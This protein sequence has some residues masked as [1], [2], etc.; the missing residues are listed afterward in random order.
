MRIR[1]F[2]N[3]TQLPKWLAKYNQTYFRMFTLTSAA[4]LIVASG[5]DDV[6]YE[7]TPGVDKTFGGSGKDT[8][9]GSLGADELH[10]EG[11]TDVIDYSKSPEVQPPDD[12]P[13]TSGGTDTDEPTDEPSDEPS[14][15]PTDG[16]TDGPVANVSGGG[17]Q[18]EVDFISGITVNLTTNINLG[19]FAE[20]DRLFT[21]ENVI[22]SQFRDVI[23]GDGE[24]NEI[25][26]L[27]GNDTLFGKA[28][29]DRLL[30]GDGDDLLY[31]EDGDDI[32]IGEAGADRLDGGEG[33]DTASYETS[34]QGVSVNLM[35]GIH[36][37]DALGDTY[38][39]IEQLMGSD[40]DDSLTGSANDDKIDGLKGNDS[41]YGEAGG[42]TL[43]GGE[44][45]DALNGG[46]GIDK[47]LLDFSNY[48]FEV[49]K[50][51]NTL[52]VHYLAPSGLEIDL[53]NS[54]ETVVN[55]DGT[56]VDI[57]TIW[58]E[59]STTEQSDFTNEADFLS[60][61]GNDSGYNYEGL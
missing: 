3:K 56:I 60:W 2:G 41:L 8:F 51:D 58:S 33:F 25:S 49:E 57:K 6:T 37:N 28:G 5:V 45:G 12:N 22:G 55:G 1:E 32:L 26:G 31:G 16:P 52:S 38:I 61:L 17:E 21:I 18:A 36:T 30:G 39:S 47:V 7:G 13:D 34:A 11:G 59:L 19:G 15:E 40:F 42:D 54:V 4:A 27:G 24:K 23:T 53:L 10:G 46:D 29:N 35:T 20:G 14:D 50:A 43:S 44:G 9:L 48:W